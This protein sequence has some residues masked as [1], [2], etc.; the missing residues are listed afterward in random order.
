[1]KVLPSIWAFHLKCFPDGLVKKF[2]VRFCI[3]G[4]KQV[5][6]IDFFEVW[7]SF[8]EWR[9]V[10]LMMMLSLKLNLLQCKQILQQ[11]F[12]MLNSFLGHLCPSSPR[13]PEIWQCGLKLNRSLYKL[14]SMLP[15]Q[16]LERASEKHKV[17]QSDL[18]PCLFT[19]EK[20]ILDVCKR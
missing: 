12:Y 10:C 4:D 2:K 17:M 19:R 7:S 1:M 16:I 3:H 9:T 11:L 13:I 15:F 6:G 5:K 20:V 18:D 8:V 14:K